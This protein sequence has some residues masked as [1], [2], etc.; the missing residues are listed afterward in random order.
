M[1]ILYGLY[2]ADAGTIR[3]RGAEARIGGPRDAIARGIGM[4]HQHFMLVPP[5]TIAENVVLGDERSGFILDR[6]A[7]EARVREL[8]DRFGLAIDPRRAS[9]PSP[10]ASSSGSRSSR[11]STAAPRSSSSTSPPPCSRRRRSTSSS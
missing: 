8:S 10:S 6:R 11:S 9:R 3:I 1:N 7:V 5:L 2:R 4:I